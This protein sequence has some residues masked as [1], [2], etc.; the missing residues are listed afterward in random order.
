MSGLFD[1]ENATDLCGIGHVHCD[2]PHG[3]VLKVRRTAMHCDND[4]RLL[5]S[6]T[7]CVDEVAAHEPTAARYQNP[8]G[9]SPLCLAARVHHAFEI[10]LQHS[11]IMSSTEVFG[12]QP[13]FIFALV[14]S[15]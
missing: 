4:F 14:H 2:K 10:G 13:S 7:Q 8:Q 5:R 15:E 9:W 1:G 12:R 3:S 11:A 6:G